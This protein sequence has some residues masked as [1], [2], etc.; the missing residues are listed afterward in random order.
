MTEQQPDAPDLGQVLGM[1][2]EDVRSRL[3]SPETDRVI[4]RDRWLVYSTGEWRLRLRLSPASPATEPV[5]RSWT[6]EPT[7]GG[8]D[9]TALLRRLGVVAEGVIDGAPGS[10]GRLMRCELAHERVPGSLTARLT[11]G[12]ISSV[13]AFDEAP[14]WSVG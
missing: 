2:G 5:V 4:G 10:A 12:S 7:A 13:T 3:G 11:A 14:D 6:F 8:S 9:L 1:G